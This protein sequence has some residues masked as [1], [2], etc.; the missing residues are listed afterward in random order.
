MS[1]RGSALIEV[2][3]ALVILAAAGVS[4]MSYLSAFLDA[5][6]R[7][8]LRE[9]ESLRAER[10]L[11]A[12]ALL[13]REDLDVRLGLR[14]VGDFLISVNRPAPSLYRIAVSAGGQPETELLVTVVF[15]ADATPGTLP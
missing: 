10:L 4:T 8:Q 9:V 11:A 15:R 13:N 6:A 2:L 1:R 5:Q 3:V 14:Q 7:V 12:T